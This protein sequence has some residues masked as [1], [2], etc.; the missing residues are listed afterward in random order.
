MPRRL[1]ARAATAAAG[2]NLDGP[3]SWLRKLDSFGGD[4][5]QAE[6]V[7]AFIESAE[8]RGHFGK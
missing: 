3:N 7:R 2:R 5:R 1:T 6:T 4:Y 8:Y